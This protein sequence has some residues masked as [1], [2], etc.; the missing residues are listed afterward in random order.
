M[1]KTLHL[2]EFSA[3]GE[4]LSRTPQYPFSHWTHPLSYNKGINFRR[5]NLQIAT[6]CK[7]SNGITSRLVRHCLASGH[8]NLLVNL[9]EQEERIGEMGQKCNSLHQNHLAPQ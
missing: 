7:N 5:N 9:S 2:W 3:C 1:V 4:K 6:N 8:A